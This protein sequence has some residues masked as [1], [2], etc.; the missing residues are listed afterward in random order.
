[1]AGTQDIDQVFERKLSENK[2][3]R[4]DVIKFANE[5][6]L[7]AKHNIGT[8]QAVLLE[9]QWATFMF[10][11]RFLSDIRKEITNYFVVNW[12]DEKDMILKPGLVYIIIGILKYALDYTASNSTIVLS[13]NVYEHTDEISFASILNHYVTE[14]K[15]IRSGGTTSF[16]F[17]ITELTNAANKYNGY[18]NQFVSFFPLIHNDLHDII[19]EILN[20][21]WIMNFNAPPLSIKIDKFQ[22]V[23]SPHV[24]ESVNFLRTADQTIDTYKLEKHKYLDFLRLIHAYHAFLDSRVALTHYTTQHAWPVYD[25]QYFFDATTRAI[26]PSAKHFLA[27]GVWKPDYEVQR[28]RLSADL[29]KVLDFVIQW[30]K[31]VID[32]CLNVEHDSAVKKR[33]PSHILEAGNASLQLRHIY[34]SVWPDGKMAN[35]KCI[36]LYLFIQRETDEIIIPW[37]IY[38][39]L[40]TVLAYKSQRHILRVNIKS[41]VN[42]TIV[43]RVRSDLLFEHRIPCSRFNRFHYPSNKFNK[44]KRENSEVDPYALRETPSRQYFNIIRTESTSAIPLSR[45]LPAFITK[46]NTW[47]LKNQIAYS[48]KDAVTEEALDWSP[49]I[50]IDLEIQRYEDRMAEQATKIIPVVVSKPGKADRNFNFSAFGEPKR[51]MSVGP[52]LDIPVSSMISSPDSDDHI[53]EPIKGVQWLDDE[54]KVIVPWTMPPSYYTSPSIDPPDKKLKLTPASPILEIDT[55]TSSA[56]ATTQTPP[57]SPGYDDPLSPEPSAPILDTDTFKSSIHNPDGTINWDD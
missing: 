46:E 4:L 24:V 20:I 13:T 51:E 48:A 32:T 28:A 3:K 45:V 40:D 42:Q 37:I 41:A 2:Q 25:E 11:K 9:T 44:R 29:C 52:E 8:N 38:V 18:F 56:A 16:M 55:I 39:F 21:P 30:T 17:G 57:G 27:E 5:V 1:M 19:E 47:T 26:L 49:R 53:Y 43:R 7:F 36:D 15:K 31:D 50:L 22:L 54:G 14:D 23:L 6:L 10:K 12:N 33:L 35:P 34:W